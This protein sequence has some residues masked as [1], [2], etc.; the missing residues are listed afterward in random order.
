MGRATE[1]AAGFF[2]D[3][4]EGREQMKS[5]D[6]SII[7]P[8]Y[9][10]SQFLQD[11]LDSVIKQTCRNIEIIC[12]DDA[13]S[14]GSLEIL[15]QYSTQDQRI[16]VIAKSVNE[17]TSK[18]RKDGVCCS[19]GNHILFLDADDRMMEN[20][21]ERLLEAY[22]E[23][24]ADIIQFDA[25][26]N[27]CN[28]IDKNKV[29]E[30]KKYLCPCC[31][32]VS[33]DK[34]QDLCFGIGSLSHSLWG[35]M[36][37]GDICRKA[38]R[39]VSDEK[40]VMAEDLYAYFIIT[41]FSQTYVGIPDK[42]YQYNYGTGI[43]GETRSFYESFEHNSKQLL[44]ASRCFEFIE[45][46]EEKEK[47]ASLVEGIR[48]YLLNT[49]IHFWIDNDKMMGEQ[50]TEL[51]QNILSNNCSS[52]DLGY[53]SVFLG[54]YCQNQELS[55]RNRGWV[56]PYDNVP[57]GSRIIIY[58]AGTVGRDYYS[59]VS[60]TGYCKIAAWVDRAYDRL[61]C[62]ENC[63]ESP[64]IIKYTDYDY[65]VIAIKDISVRNVV[66]EYLLSIHV[67]ENLIV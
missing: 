11:C 32:E 29:D 45:A 4:L 36:F 50:D 19:V 30:V 55:M 23:K 22:I 6:F 42:L 47:Y 63:I 60:K 8:I 31:E 48:K 52:K 62:N 58:G 12:I 2:E 20:A 25:Y 17:G 37:D 9:N 13:S 5:I 26:I 10:A 46:I 51:L 54:I 3:G 18:A 34:V 14:D 41:V 64:E 15:K 21:C 24:P 28:G 7:I 16:R 39:Y 59:Q 35:K 43:T 1:P 53:I 61:D 40:M 33:I 67:Q 57:K 56:F 27:A 49:F 44:V 66:K 65:I 38:F